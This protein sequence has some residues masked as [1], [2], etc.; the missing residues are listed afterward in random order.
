MVLPL[1]MG[2]GHD[3]WGL[4]SHVAGALEEYEEESRPEGL[5]ARSRAWRGL[6]VSK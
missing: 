4:G 3:G 5:P 6:L 2:L 1:D